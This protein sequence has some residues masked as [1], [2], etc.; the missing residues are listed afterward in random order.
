MI[1]LVTAFG[2]VG[3]VVGALLGAVAVASIRIP[4]AAGTKN[5]FG[6]L[7]WIMFT[8]CCSTIAWMLALSSEW[9]GDG[10]H[11][12][13]FYFLVLPQLLCFAIRYYLYHDRPKNSPK[14]RLHTIQNRI[15]VGVCLVAALAI[16]TDLPHRLR[17]AMQTQ[18]LDGTAKDIKRKCASGDAP[19]PTFANRDVR[20]WNC[21]KDA[22]SFEAGTWSKLFDRG[23]TWGFAKSVLPPTFNGQF[24]DFEEVKPLGNNWW[25]WKQVTWRD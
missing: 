3:T 8:L 22:I 23:G 13:V 25:V 21:T 4:T 18:L 16:A 14:M 1:A 2:P 6:T 24:G 17:I 11:W 20:S 12:L 9:F 7:S 19:V 5:R 15:L 10:L